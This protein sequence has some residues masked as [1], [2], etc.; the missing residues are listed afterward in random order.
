MKYKGKN[1]DTYSEIVDY[2]LS[3]SG[4]EQ[5]KFVE[6]YAK[7]GPYALQNIGY[8]SG[9]YG[10]EKMAKI[11]EVFKTAHPIFGRMQPTQTEAFEAGVAIGRKAKEGEK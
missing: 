4:E 2:A 9:Y 6:K 1:L 3:L 5:E 7:S 11:Q 10:P 8:W